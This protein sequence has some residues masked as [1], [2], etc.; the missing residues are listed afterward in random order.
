MVFQFCEWPRAW[1]APICAARQAGE[2][3][4][5]PH[6]RGGCQLALPMG[7]RAD[8]GRRDKRGAPLRDTG[9]ARGP[10]RFRLAAAMAPTGMVVEERTA[11]RATDR[12]P[13]VR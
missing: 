3:R 1:G 13:K 10:L 11:S 12:Y 2:P 6:A 7:R 4:L 8:A 9:A 5:R